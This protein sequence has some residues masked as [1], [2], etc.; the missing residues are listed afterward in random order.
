[1]NSDNIIAL[2]AHSIEHPQIGDFLLGINSSTESAAASAGSLNTKIRIKPCGLLFGLVRRKILESTVCS[3]RLTATAIIWCL[4]E[5]VIR[6]L[7][8]LNFIL[9][10]KVP[11]RLI[12]SLDMNEAAITQTLQTPPIEIIPP[13]TT[14]K[15]FIDFWVSHIKYHRA[16]YILDVAYRDGHVYWYEIALTD[17]WQVEKFNLQ[18][19]YPG[20]ARMGKGANG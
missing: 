11:C 8:K 7:L 19:Q 17:S 16:P 20:Y 6:F 1:M 10:L 5:A 3:Q 18:A 15:F 12:I 2:F 14:D 13:S 4:N 9:D